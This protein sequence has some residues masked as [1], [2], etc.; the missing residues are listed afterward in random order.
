MGGRAVPGLL[1]PLERAPGLL[2]ALEPDGWTCG[3]GPGLLAA[4]DLDAVIFIVGFLP[5][6]GLGGS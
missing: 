5:P 4:L 1:T 2:A 6:G 3:S